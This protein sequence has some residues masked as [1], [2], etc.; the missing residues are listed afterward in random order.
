MMMV[1]VMQDAKFLHSCTDVEERHYVSECQRTQP[2][3]Y[4]CLAR[5]KARK[6]EPGCYFT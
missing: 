1:M 6:S 5:D 3:T 4:A 2:Q